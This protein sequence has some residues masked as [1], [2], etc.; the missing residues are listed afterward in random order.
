[1]EC[2]SGLRQELAVEGAVTVYWN[3]KYYAELLNERLRA[4]GDNILHENLFI[5]LSCMAMIH[6][7]DLYNFPFMNCYANVVV[8]WQHTQIKRF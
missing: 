6:V 7:P 2:T 5:V 3:R 8:G 1:M 4:S